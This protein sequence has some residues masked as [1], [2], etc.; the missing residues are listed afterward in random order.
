ME[1]S[2]D[3]I[4]EVVKG[5]IKGDKNKN[6]C[7]VAPFNDAKDDCPLIYGTASSERGKNGCPQAPKIGT[8]VVVF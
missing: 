8:K 4:A 1:L 3:R 5:E 2:L 6:I 7:G